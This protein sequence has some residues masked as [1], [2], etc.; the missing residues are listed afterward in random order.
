M[1]A[2]KIVILYKR[3]AQP[4]TQL[5]SLL[6]SA[7]SPPEY[8]VF[9]DRHLKIG[10][11]WARVIEEKIRGADAVIA[12]LSD[13][14]LSS[15][16]LEYEIEITLDER[17]RHQAP[18]LLPIRIGSDLPPKGTVGSLLSSIQYSTWNGDRKS[19]RLNSSH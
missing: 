6:E 17:L 10:V 11:E 16:M 18:L 8:D 9:I 2:K 5:L 15:E 7:L 3:G 12:L 1:A 4:D 19:T 13:A 14:S